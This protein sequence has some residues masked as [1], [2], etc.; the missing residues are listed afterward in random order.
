MPKIDELAVLAKAFGDKLA[1]V[2]TGISPGP[3]TW[4]PYESLSNFPALDQTLTGDSRSLLDLADGKPILDI[5]CADGDLAFFLESLGCRVD[6]IDNPITN[7][8]ALCGVKTLKA[9]LG[10]SVGIH[11]MD[12]DADF[13]LPADDYG[14]V[15]LL[16]VLYHLKN[17][18][19]VLEKLAKYTRYCLLSTALTSTV[20]AVEPD[21]SNS[22]LGFLASEREMNG[23]ATVYWIFTDA[24][25][26]RLLDRTNWEI[27]DCR[28]FPTSDRWTG[29]RV[30]CL[31]KSKF[32]DRPVNV[33]YGRGW[34]AVE[35]GGW[36]WTERQFAVRIEGT[37]KSNASQLRL[38]LY[39]PDAVG[40]I[41]IDAIAN[42]VALA[43]ETYSNPGEHEFVRSLAPFST[44]TGDIRI[45][46]NLSSA[47][48]PDSTDRRER[49]IIVA[50]IT[51]E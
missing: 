7:F 8:N 4:Y 21:V 9:A 43:P 24:G 36:R 15:L 25:F 39:V 12:L 3:F 23:D 45:D 38:R 28:V 34:H 14:L 26:R 51:A 48:P 11:A 46:F 47:L 2:K 6:A 32:A 17:P 42:G 22:P 41:T 19:F 31:A 33:L 50:S 18:F 1:S 13:E 20:P 27:C 30:F 37:R 16:G 40:A 49:G 10:S 35:E 5:G 44:A 29:L